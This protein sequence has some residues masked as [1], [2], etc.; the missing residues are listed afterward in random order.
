MLHMFVVSS[1]SSRWPQQW[2]DR[3]LGS[4]WL[5]GVLMMA[6]TSASHAGQRLAHGHVDDG[7]DGGRGGDGAAQHETPDAVSC[8]RGVDAEGWELVL[9][10]DALRKEA[11]QR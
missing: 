7:V 10:A 6:L 2:S 1:T 4:G 5:L 11:G 8:A 3:M 9:V